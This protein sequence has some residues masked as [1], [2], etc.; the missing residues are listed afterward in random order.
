[1]PMTRTFPVYIS[2]FTMGQDTA[3]T[4]RLTT[5]RDIY[6]RDA[7]VLASFAK[8]RELKTT[9]RISDEPVVQLDNPL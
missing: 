5:Y 9:Q 7:A 3:M 2:Y 1:V 8:A 4:G 6:G